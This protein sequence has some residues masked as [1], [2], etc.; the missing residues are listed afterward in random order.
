MSTENDRMRE[1]GLMTEAASSNKEDVFLNKIHATPSWMPIFSMRYSSAKIAWALFFPYSI[2]LPA[3]FC[4]VFIWHKYTGVAYVL[5]KTSSL[6]LFLGTLWCFLAMALMKEV[7]LYRDRVEQK[8]RF[9]KRTVIVELKD[10]VYHPGRKFMIGSYLKSFS[11]PNKPCTFSPTGM[12][13]V[14]FDAYLLANS[15]LKEFEMALASV[16]ERNLEEIRSIHPIKLINEDKKR[17]GLKP[18]L[19]D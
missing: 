8:F 5:L 17:P 15:D 18:G 19:S 7:V 12:R 13:G 4:M 6:L 3:S 2:M 10:A 11:A 14:A 16:C 1:K 9:F